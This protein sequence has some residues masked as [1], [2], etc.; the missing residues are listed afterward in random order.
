MTRRG[1]DGQGGAAEHKPE[2]ARTRRKTYVVDPIPTGRDMTEFKLQQSASK[3]ERSRRGQS[4]ERI[5]I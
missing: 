5:G 2:P 3:C 1:R 4:E